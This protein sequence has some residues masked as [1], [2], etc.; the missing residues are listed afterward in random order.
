M[1]ENLYQTPQSE[2]VEEEEQLEFYV[3]SLKK[4]TLLYFFT[5]GLYG[6]YWFYKHWREYKFYH[7]LSLWPVPRAIFNIFFVYSLF[8]RIEERLKRNQAPYS[9][10]AQGLAIGYIII[11]VVGKISDQISYNGGETLILELLSF[12]GMGVAYFILYQAQK[13]VNF[14]L[15]DPQGSRNSQFTGANYVWMIFGAIF[16]LLVLI[17]LLGVVAEPVVH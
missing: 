17:G 10:A 12:M 5:F 9:F 4:F 16:W 11:S 6:I 1:E 15:N 7:R 14:A 2:V 8:S 3:V 13:A